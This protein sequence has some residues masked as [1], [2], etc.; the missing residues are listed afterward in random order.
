MTKTSH[1]ILFAL[2][3]LV[4]T[5]TPTHRAA[6]A[7][8]AFFLFQ[9]SA[10]ETVPVDFA[11]NYIVTLTYSNASGTLDNAVFTNGVSI[12]PSGQGVT[13]SLDPF[14]PPIA[15]SGGT[16]T[17]PL[18]ISAPG[19]T[20]PN[21]T[22]TII[23]SATNKAFTANVP[24]GIFLLTNTF[25]VGGSAYSNGFT[26]AL[27]STSATCPAG[28][29]TNFASTVTLEDHSLTLSGTVTNGV[30]VS[31]PG[32]GVTAGLNSIYA[33]IT[34]HFGQTNLTLTINVDAGAAPG[35]Y[36]VTVKGT[37]AA[38]TANTPSGVASA[39][40]ALNITAAKKFTL[41]VTPA[42]E[43]VVG[44]VASKVIAT[45]TLTNLSTVIVETITNGVTVIGPDTV[46]VTAGLSP[47]YV[48]P[49]AGGGTAALSLSITNNGSSL[50]GTYQVII[51]STNND[52]TDNRPISGVALATNLFTVSAP[53]LSIQSFSLSGMNL[54]FIGCG[55]GPSG[56][57]VVCS[58]TNLTLPLALWTPVTTNL[59]DASGNFNALIALANTPNP[60][61]PRQFFTTLFV[62][63]A[64]PV[65][66]PT[67]SPA[68]RSYFDETPVTIT[69][70]TSNAIIRY[71]TD[72][73]TPSE[74][75]GALY[76]GPVT[77]HKP[78]NTNST[79]TITN[80][81]GVTMLKAVA[82]K[83]GLPASAV[84]TGIYTILDPVAYPP[85]SVPS[86]L[87]GISHM[88]YN[89]TSSN[90]DDT[91]SLWTNYYGLGTVVVSS[92]FTLIKINDQ[93]YIEMY[94]VP[95]LVSNQWQLANYGFEV[96]NAEAY[97]QQ[98]A[99][100][101]VSV[102]ASVSTNRLGN[103]SFFSV[104]PDGHTNEWVQYLTNSITGLSQGRYM[105]GTAVVG[106]ANCFGITTTNGNNNNVTGPPIDYY[107]T[108]CGF[109][110]TGN[111]VD[112]PSGG[113]VY[114]EL[115]T[116]GPGGATQDMAGK[117]GKL[118]FM[119]FRGMTL[120]QTINILTNRNPSIP[121]VLA[122]ENRHF[123]FDVD[124]LDLS[125]IRINDY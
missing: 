25:I 117:H 65:A 2:L 34:N 63:G 30:T 100:N 105:P 76:T 26:M 120:F 122:P 23:V 78:V 18:T 101:G 35:A 24:S 123:A 6:A 49:S 47:V 55:G 40:F 32:Q 51:G 95:L 61:A 29:A 107:I 57:Y 74:S 59:F 48:S 71:T 1:S 72:G 87:C 121:Y 41:S 69:S 43:T 3:A 20:T 79:G 83:G 56:E 13:V 4:L 106:F 70:A 85:A 116:T 58:A 62:M 16:G 119:N 90:W 45:V 115:L 46:K 111:S 92:D 14:S 86:P 109:Q 28:I 53:P 91:L 104:D 27:S 98:L 36:T 97:R 102:P 81:S 66:T 103:L 11:T 96:T 15:K 114:I 88:A 82:Y 8:K 52:F 94:R 64:N 93:Q 113:K 19:N 31:P 108:N 33:P 67:F 7:Q 118:Q 39:I 12:T 124:T 99:A 80:A 84:W 73:S 50:P 54:T 68:A 42:A 75:N 89:V 77:M 60:N 125:R 5:G 38:F 17:L 9:S 112:I 110:G 21:T 22:C 44:G 10:T 37:N